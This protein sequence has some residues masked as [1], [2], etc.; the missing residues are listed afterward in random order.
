M[1]N[2]RKGVRVPYH[3]R[4]AER[5]SKIILIILYIIDNH[6]N[7]YKFNKKITI[8]FKFLNQISFDKLLSESKL[9]NPTSSLWR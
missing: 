9:S 5:N 2:R 7:F 4:G 1:K 6:L 8:L 3:A